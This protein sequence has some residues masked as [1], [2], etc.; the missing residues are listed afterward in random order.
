MPNE[1]DVSFTGLILVTGEDR[2]G[3]TQILMESLSQFSVKI[4]DIEQ[5]V[6]RN[7]LVLTILIALDEAH[8][9]AI[10]QDLIQLQE[11]LK[12][13]IAVDFVEH[14]IEADDRENLRVI[15]VAAELKPA[16]V[17]L[18]AAQISKLGGNITAIKRTA[19]APLLAIEF[20]SSIPND[21]LKLVQKT[22]AGVALSNGI[23]LAVQ[24]GGLVRNAQR[25]V[26]LDMDSTL[27]QQEVI[28]LLAAHAGKS[29]QIQAI[30]ERAMNG[31]MDFVQALESRVD[32]LAGLDASII[33]T[34]QKEITLTT[35]AKT[36]IE[37]LHKRG[38]KI[39]VVSGGFLEVITPLLKSL[40]VDLIIANQLEIMDGLL[41]GKLKGQ[42]I[43]AIAKKEA[44]ETFA[45]T[46]SIPMSQTVAIGDGANDLEMIQAAGLG[47]AFN[48]RP[49]IAAAADST[50]NNKDLSTVLL[51]M[52][53]SN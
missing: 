26:M 16:N 38:H 44:L 18:I 33:H 32:L 17:S 22:L 49:K 8:A 14:K 9:Q 12:L 7:R 41:T 37:S 29:A 6:I 1:K 15:M 47:I 51:M 43:D 3:I 10:A 19:I 23:D 27:I 45:R 50:I 25:I 28:N 36:L 40:K 4:L 5:L 21:S 42:V 20:E 53:I 31:E 39:G 11:Q 30:T 34:V 46:E 35:G 13:D 2:P 48:A 24:P 52:G